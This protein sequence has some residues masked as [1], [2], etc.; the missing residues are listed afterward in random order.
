[1]AGGTLNLPPGTKLEISRLRRN[2][3]RLEFRYLD[4]MVAQAAY[5]EIRDLLRDGSLCLM[6]ETREG[7]D[8]ERDQP[9]ELSRRAARPRFGQ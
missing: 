2:R 4:A 6:V 9:A 3:V 5:D 7:R 1:M 8:D